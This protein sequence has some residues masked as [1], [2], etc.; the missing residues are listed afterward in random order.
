MPSATKPTDRGLKTNDLYWC[1][2]FKAD[3]PS[4]CELSGNNASIQVVVDDMVE[5]KIILSMSTQKYEEAMRA[6]KGR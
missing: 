3:S 6:Y 4:D 2:Q 1:T 5:N